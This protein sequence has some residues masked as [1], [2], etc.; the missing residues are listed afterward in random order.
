MNPGYH[1][2]AKKTSKTNSKI[3][4]PTK[5]IKTVYLNKT[6]RYNMPGDWKNELW[7]ID[8]QLNIQDKVE[9]NEFF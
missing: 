8:D 5:K 2:K 4:L 7:I 1:F 3:D 6:I 9:W